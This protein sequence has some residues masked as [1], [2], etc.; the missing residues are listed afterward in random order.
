MD[1]F[2]AE[3]PP[4]LRQPLVRFLTGEASGEITLM[5]FA[6]QFGDARLLGPILATLAGAAPERKELADLLRLV[7]TN[8]DHLAQVTALAKDGLLNIPSDDGDAV[9]AIR[10]QFD[11]AVAVAPEASV[12]LYSLGSADILDCATSEIVNRLAEWGLLRSDATMLDIGCGIGRIERALAPLVGTITAIDASS[13]MIEEARRRCGDLANVAF[14]QCGGR[15]LAKFRDRSFDLVLA[16]DSF[17]YLYA[18]DPEIIT[19]HLEDCARVLR[20]NGTLVILNFSY[21]G[22]EEADRRDIERLA[23]ANGFSIR[24][25]GTRDFTLWDGLTFLLTLPAQRE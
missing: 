19:R 17:P 20:P 13:G 21:R 8:M 3:C 22:D 1:D 7:E 18:A 25:A 5:H 24:R 2:I 10:E 23:A 16:V 14:E 12:A 6:S 4:S 9:T 11:R 15:D